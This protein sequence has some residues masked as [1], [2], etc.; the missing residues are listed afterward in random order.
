MKILSVESKDSKM[1]FSVLLTLGLSEVSSC[2][3][4]FLGA[5]AQMTG[6]PPRASRQVYVMSYVLLVLL[7]LISFG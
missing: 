2:V 7:A 6:A 3:Y 5:G 4:L 1:L